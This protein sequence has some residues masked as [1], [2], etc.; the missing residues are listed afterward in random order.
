M[1]H[2]T[3]NRNPEPEGFNRLHLI[4]AV[5]AALLSVCMHLG[6]LY[7]LSKLAWAS[8]NAE[9]PRKEQ[10]D[11]L[12]LRVESVKRELAP[13][14][15]RPDRLQVGDTALQADPARDAQE[16]AQPPGKAAIE[17]PPVAENR[18]A[19]AAAP[20]A[21]PPAMPEREAWQPR[22]EILAIQ[23]RL[24]ADTTSLLERRPI[25][26]IERVVAAPDITDVLPRDEY[27]RQLDKRAPGDERT[28]LA[29]IPGG[30]GTGTGYGPVG[31]R[32]REEK[33]V[34][35]LAEPPTRTGGD[36]FREE[37]SQITGYRAI[38]KLLKARVT[39]F[40]PRGERRY[41]YFRI[42]IERLSAAVLPV[43]P[44]DIVIVQDA[45]ASI[46][47]QRLHFCRAGLTNCLS[48][49]GPRDRFNIMSFREQAGTCFP[50]WVPSTP[51]TRRQAEQYIGGLHAQG[52]TDLFAS[53]RALMTLKRDP[54]RPVVAFVVTDGLPTAGLTGSSSI[55]GQFSA[56][57]DGAISVVTLGTIRAANGYLLDLLSYCNRGNSTVVTTG[58]WDIPMAIRDLFQT[59]SRPVM[60]DVRFRFAETGGCEVYP[61]LTENLY[62]DRPLVLYGR[63]PLATQRAAFQAVGK[64]LNVNCDMVFD[65]DLVNAPAS[66]DAEIRQA[67]ARQKIYSLIGA[68]ARD[69]RPEL[70]RDLSATSA[71]YEVP[72]PYKGQF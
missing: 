27:I 46:S 24:A 2:Y 54:G 69:P 53:M 56:L 59:V 38:E 29:G 1:M 65:L 55:I 13:A 4:A 63:F 66:G 61:V 35:D 41:G 7:V 30:G 3:Y 9:R 36:L 11:F 37:P 22:Q 58:R 14:T 10:S 72:V 5:M 57:N 16:L 21:E 42:E 18:L 25:P 68:H 8:L 6:S 51:E 23:K 48:L 47:E 26:R 52:E 71:E 39:V 12:P 49:I 20:V 60:S 28:L 44:K 64:A 40:R 50:D 15:P 43:I 31:G 19:G 70:L 33:P 45:S 32:R 67:W 34:V 62:L 17:P